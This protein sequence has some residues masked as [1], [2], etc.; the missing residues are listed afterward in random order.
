MAEPYP[1]SD[2]RRI[3]FV[4]A[5]NSVLATNCSACLSLRIAPTVRQFYF[6]EAQRHVVRLN[7]YVSSSK[8]V[9][10]LNS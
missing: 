4:P 2:R 10:P 9:S 6:G 5:N 7:I 1:F 3:C 8:S